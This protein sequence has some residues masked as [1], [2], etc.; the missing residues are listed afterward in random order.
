MTTYF[1]SRH[2]RAWLWLR[3]KIRRGVVDLKIDRWVTHLDTREIEPGDVVVGTL[4]FNEVLALQ[5]RGGRFVALVMDLPEA[6]RGRELSATEMSV[7]KARLIQ[8]R[9]EA[10]GEQR[11]RGDRSAVVEP[12]D[13][14]PHVR[15]AFVSQE[16]AP[17]FLSSKQHAGRIRHVELIASRAMAGRAEHLAS[18]LRGYFPG[19]RVTVQGMDSD[20]RDPAELLDVA[21]KTLA[22][23]GA[24]YRDCRLVAELTT[25]TKPMAMA[26]STA[27]GECAARGMAVGSL[28]TDSEAKQIQ[29]LSPPV[30]PEPL[31]VT[32]GIEELLRI[33]GI[34]SRMST[35]V[36][37][38]YR[39]EIE[40]R[41]E[42]TNRLLMGLS[43]KALGLLNDLAA[44]AERRSKSAKQDVR[45]VR[46][47]LLDKKQRDAAQDVRQEFLACIRKLAERRML[48]LHGEPGK[49][50][51]A[52]RN[53]PT[54]KYLGGGWFEEWIM[55][56]LLPHKL[57]ELAANISIRLPRLDGGKGNTRVQNE[58]D[59]VA[60]HGNRVLLIE[61][62][63]AYLDVGAGKAFNQAIYALNAKSQQMARQLVAKLLISRRPV[64]PDS[65]ELANAYGIAVLCPP[66]VP[67]A[68]QVRFMA[69][70]LQRMVAEWK[71]TGRIG[72]P[73]ELLR[74]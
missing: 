13:D 35:A 44:R 33:Q 10:I 68:D 34:P 71:A 39:S 55:L 46:V 32:L 29:W 5:A 25:G 52:F 26:L 49:Q 2:E 72:A 3:S 63:T 36:D 59:V 19:I 51:L 17:L 40:R 4:P 28:Y 27:V 56:R 31:R 8:L 70:N 23:L 22:R 38:K 65:V 41:A 67:E 54:L 20:G 37:R 7:Y 64:N 60:A 1:V 24:K 16:L 53:F 66:A 69:D 62:K 18:A 50:E 12:W 57:D 43:E 73:R 47:P 42:T 11:I 48:S 61:A 6:V 58:L 74:G 45:D 14:R 30:A 21:R 9:V 15:I